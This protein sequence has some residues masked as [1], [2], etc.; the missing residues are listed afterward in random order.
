[1]LWAM[2]TDINC[3][4]WFV[5]ANFIEWRWKLS[6]ADTLRLR[7]RCLLLELATYGNVKVQSLYRSWE[8]WGFVKVAV[9]RAVR[10][11]ECPLGELP[12]YLQGN[13]IK[14]HPKEVVTFREMALPF[15]WSSLLWFLKQSMA[16]NLCK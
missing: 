3:H 2:T 14:I 13:N 1:M 9:S 8:R 7:K 16:N 6:W 5:A 10:L 15:Q 12:L 11:W 4:A